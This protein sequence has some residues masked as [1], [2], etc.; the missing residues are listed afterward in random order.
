M[1][2]NNN[3]PNNKNEQNLAI[4]DDKPAEDYH[5]TLVGLSVGSFLIGISTALYLSRKQCNPKICKI[6]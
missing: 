5:N 1:S 3:T 4:V 2:E 6:I